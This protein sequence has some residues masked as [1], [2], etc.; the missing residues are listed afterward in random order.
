MTSLT[1]NPYAVLRIF[2]F[3][4]LVKQKKKIRLHVL[5]MKE[6][7]IGIGAPRMLYSSNAVLG[8]QNNN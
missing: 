2:V 4:K 1:G 5:R 8:Q 3:R 6:E 7:E